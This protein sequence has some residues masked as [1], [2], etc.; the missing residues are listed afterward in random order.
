[1]S[2]HSPAFLAMRND[3][4]SIYRVFT[5]REQHESTGYEEAV[6]KLNTV[7]IGGSENDENPLADE[8]GFYRIAQ[9]YDSRMRTKVRERDAE[10][11]ML[12]E[13]NRLLVEPTLLVEGIKRQR[14][15]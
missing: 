7:S 10:I 15:S 2:T 12:K 6:T 5:G 9:E 11:E 13:K 3:R 14:N 8:L 1:M 4:T